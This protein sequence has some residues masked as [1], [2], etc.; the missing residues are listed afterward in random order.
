MGIFIVISNNIQME[1]FKE[2]FKVFFNSFWPCSGHKNYDFFR[3]F[4]PWFSKAFGNFEKTLET[5]WITYP[6]ATFSFT[7]GFVKWSFP[8]GIAFKTRSDPE[9]IL[10]LPQHCWFSM[11]KKPHQNGPQNETYKV[12]KMF[13]NFD[14]YSLFTLSNKLTRPDQNPTTLMFSFGLLL[15]QIILHFFTKVPLPLT[16]TEQCQLFHG[17]FG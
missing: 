1:S 15:C 2:H 5:S 10:I 9:L 11:L 4:S 3:Q 13:I 7:Y 8:L 16:F 6:S 14:R 12:N 17:L